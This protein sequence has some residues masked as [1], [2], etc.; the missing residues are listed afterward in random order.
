MGFNVVALAQK[1][2]TQTLIVDSDLDMGQYDLIA[3]DVKGDTAEFSEFVGGVGNFT[4]GLF[5]DGVDVSGILHAESNLQV[6]GGI[7]LEGS[8]NNVN[9]TPEGEITT[10]QGI[11]AADFNGVIF[12][13]GKIVVSSYS[14]TSGI[15][16][17][18]VPQLG[19]SVR[20]LSTA[21]TWENL[22]T[23]TYVG[24]SIFEVPTVSGQYTVAVHIS[25]GNI[26]NAGCRLFDVTT[27]TPLLE[28]QGD[29]G[30][31]TSWAIS[32]TGDVTFTSGHTYSI[33]GN[34]GSSTAGNKVE[35]QCTGIENFYI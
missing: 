14:T 22:S 11:N 15:L 17:L 19:M 1:P 12:R 2:R 34:R 28:I 27:N 5:S 21:N 23:F 29:I 32:K 18:N 13:N 6:D 3:T 20:T 25:S 33:Q 10:S 24:S 8:I 35:T 26:S 4:N 16:V 31:S 30:S 9:I 7:S